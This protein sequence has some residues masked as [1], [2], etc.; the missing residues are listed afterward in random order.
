[1]PM[2]APYPGPPVMNSIE[3]PN[4]GGAAMV[5]PPDGTHML[6]GGYPHSHPHLP[7][8][9]LHHHQQQHHNGYHYP[10]PLQP[11]QPAYGLPVGGGYDRV[12]VH[13]YLHHV[14]PGTQ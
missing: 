13:Q 10:L 14:G 5:G 3:H 1:M 7:P 9:H 8:H 2:S 6:G 11:E 4:Y 12:L